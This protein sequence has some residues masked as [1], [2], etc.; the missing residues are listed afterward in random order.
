MDADKCI[1]NAHKA[2]AAL[3]NLNVPYQR[4]MKK[5]N[6]Y[7]VMG[8]KQTK[9]GKF[10]LGAIEFMENGIVGLTKLIKKTSRATM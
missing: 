1:D 6:K 3:K 8:M 7:D 9:D 10:I 2:L 4:G 5:M